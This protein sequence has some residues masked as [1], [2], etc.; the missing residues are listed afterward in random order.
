MWQKQSVF[1]RRV[2]LMWYTVVMVC[3]FHLLDETQVMSNLFEAWHLLVNKAY[4]AVTSTWSTTDKNIAWPQ[5]PA[6]SRLNS[7]ACAFHQQVSEISTHKSCDYS[8]ADCGPGVLLQRAVRQAVLRLSG[9]RLIRELLAWASSVMDTLP[10]C[11]MK[12]ATE[13]SSSGVMEINFPLSSITPAGNVQQ[14]T[15]YYRG[16]ND[17]IKGTTGTVIYS[18]SSTHFYLLMVK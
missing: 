7:P 14:N 1:V 12:W 4:W 15:V 3:S 6:N 17:N 13:S 18:R 2:N 16:F 9:V 11:L 5:T 8:S 10:L